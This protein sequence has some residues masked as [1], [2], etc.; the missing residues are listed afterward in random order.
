MLKKELHSEL[1]KFGWFVVVFYLFFQIWY[2]KDSPINVLK[3]V[4]AQLYLFILPGF[5]LMLYYRN[6][7]EFMHRLIMGIALGYSA[8]II[9]TIFIAV[10]I[11]INIVYYYWISPLIIIILGLYGFSRAPK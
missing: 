3:I 4:F 1:K 10:V 7:I 2:F 9:L 5:M 11:K 8:S 6:K